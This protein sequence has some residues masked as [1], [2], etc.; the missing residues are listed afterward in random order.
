MKAKQIG[1]LLVALIVIG[2]AGIVVRLLATEST[3]PVLQ[4]LNSLSEDVIDK[5]VIRDLDSESTLVKREDGEWWV[6]RYPVLQIRL[7]DLWDTVV[8]FEGAELVATNTEYHRWMGV[9]P[10]NST[11][12]Q[13]FRGDQTVE[14]FFVGDKAYS[15]VA[16]EEKIYSPWNAGSRQ[17]FL[18]PPDVVET[19]AVRCDFPDRFLTDPRLWSD[20]IVVRVPRDEVDV[21]SFRYPD[22][23]FDLANVQ[24]VWLLGDESQ[25]LKANTDSIQALLGELEFLVTRDFPTDEEA[26]ELDFSKPNITLGITTKRGASQRSTVLLFL[27]RESGGYYVKDINKTWVYILDDE[28]SALVLKTR[29]ELL[30][31]PPTEPSEGTPLAAPETPTTPAH[32]TTTA[33]TS[34]AAAAPSR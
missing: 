9:S 32:V 16:A 13:F 29:Q 8:E 27:E 10:E 6:G 17:C 5:I 18:R 19:Y 31:P 23:R 12:V 1:Y 22:D 24:S 25:Q 30:S 26:D 20:P 14:T 11:F 15:P 33:T 7:R 3:V 21:L 28:A 2:V 4:G 34:T